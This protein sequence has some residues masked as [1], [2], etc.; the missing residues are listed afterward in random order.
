MTLNA[1]SS[2]PI[3]PTLYLKKSTLVVSGTGTSTDPYKLE[4][5]N[6]LEGYAE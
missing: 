6:N 1:Y 4:D 3:I 5:P 2:Y